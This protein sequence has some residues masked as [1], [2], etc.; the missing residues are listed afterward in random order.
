MAAGQTSLRVGLFIAVGAIAIVALV[1]GTLAGGHRAALGYLG[2]AWD[3]FWAAIPDIGILMLAA[4][5]TGGGLPLPTAARG[6]RAPV[7]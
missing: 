7:R 1:L 2:D 6:P 4:K 3:S 5:A